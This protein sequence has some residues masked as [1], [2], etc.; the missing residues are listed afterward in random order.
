MSLSKVVDLLHAAAELNRRTPLRNAQMI[1]FPSGIGES[2]ANELLVC[3]DLH[4]HARNFEKFQ[5]VAALARFPRRHVLLQEIIHGGPLGP[6]GEDHSFDMLLQ[7]AEWSRQFPGRVHFL[8]SNHDMAQVQKIAIMKDGYDLTDRFTRYINQYYG[9]SAPAVHDAFNQFVYSM[10]LAAITVSGVFFSH[11]LPGPRDL[12][13]FDATIVRRELTL[14][15]YARNGPVYQ[16]IWGRYQNQEVLSTL[17][18]AWWAELFVCGHQAQNEGHGILGDRM[19]II[20]SSHNH[21]VFL[22]IDL[23]RQYTL[24]DLAA[25]VKPLASV[26]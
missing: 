7:A 23:S 25:A 26:M 17:S 12:A 11:S 6:S 9:S 4:N 5:K 21:G 8:L 10:P 1:C 13:S 15:D 22:P 2:E 16:L 18:H 24:H 14:A 20:D 3:G 19:L